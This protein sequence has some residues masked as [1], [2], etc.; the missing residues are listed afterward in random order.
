MCP[1]NWDIFSRG[2]TTP[3]VRVRRLPERRLSCRGKVKGLW[4]RLGDSVTGEKLYKRF[5][6][7]HRGEK[8]RKKKTLRSSPAPQSEADGF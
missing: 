6:G 7:A 5:D 8:K 2:L 1:N 3:R 4:K